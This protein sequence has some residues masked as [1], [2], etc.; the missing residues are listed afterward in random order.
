MVLG[1]NPDHV[2]LLQPTPYG[3][4]APSASSA[5]GEFPPTSRGSFSLQPPPTVPFDPTNV[6]RTGA[7]EPAECKAARILRAQNRGHD[8][9]MMAALCAAKGGDAGL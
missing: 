8:A 9:D 3:S 4:A 7:G 6:T 2:E 1:K 5:T